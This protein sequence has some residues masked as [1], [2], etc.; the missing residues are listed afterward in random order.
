MGRRPH[1]LATPQALAGRI[2]RDKE[3]PE[4]RQLRLLRM[5]ARL[6][7]LSVYELQ[8]MHERQHGQCAICSKVIDLHVDGRKYGGVNIDHDHATGRVRG[9]LCTWCN[10]GLA[11]YAHLAAHDAKVSLYLKEEE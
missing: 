11:Y 8:A 6:Y 9:L 4:K 7:G 2:A 3:T 10:K 5:R 1:I